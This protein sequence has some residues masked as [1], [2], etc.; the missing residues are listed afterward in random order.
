[1][2]VDWEQNKPQNEQNIDARFLW[3]LNKDGLNKDDDKFYIEQSTDGEKKAR[4]TIVSDDNLNE[5]LILSAN[6]AEENEKTATKWTLCHVI[7]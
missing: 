7:N 5:T 1:M 3:H 2:T 4:L 6:Y